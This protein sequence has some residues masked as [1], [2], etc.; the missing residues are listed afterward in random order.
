MAS[1]LNDYPRY[2]NQPAGKSVYNF[3]IGV[4]E[5]EKQRR[6]QQDM[7]FIEST[8]PDKGQ[9]RPNQAMVRQA[10][11][12]LPQVKPDS[13]TPISTG[14]PTADLSRNVSPDRYDPA[15]DRRGQRNAFEQPLMA[16]G[17]QPTNF[18]GVMY[19][20]QG[21]QTEYQQPKGSMTFQGGA[22]GVPGR[23][24]GGT[25]SVLG[26]RTPEEQ[27]AIDKRVKSI[28]SQTAAMRGLR[29][30]NRQEQ[31]M[32]TVEQEKQLSDMQ[33]MMR[34]LAPPPNTSRLD[35]QQA[36]LMQQLKDA[37]GIKGFGKRRQR[38]DAIRAAQLGLAQLAGLRGELNQQYGQ[39][40]GLAQSMM[41]NQAAQ[42]SAQAKALQDQQK[43]LANYGLTKEA[44]QIA[45]QKNELDAAQAGARQTLDQQRYSGDTALKMQEA[46]RRLYPS[47]AEQKLWYTEDI[48]NPGKPTLNIAA[49]GLSALPSD[50]AQVQPEGIYLQGETPVR[51]DENGN[52]VPIVGGLGMAVFLNRAMQMKKLGAI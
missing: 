7:A 8:L 40:A 1:P 41:Q 14:V 39:Q 45:Q 21:G 6:N 13:A 5:A 34:G 25:L 33:Q 29:N 43:W 38:E 30:A 12:V 36:A 15:V 50:K 3:L 11:P 26:G 4:P 16:E 23:Q 52:P 22:L 32:M 49:T 35:E 48:N 18:D 17:Y 19:R 27:A 37:Q 42:E 10:I 44:N 24:G 9:D 51:I 20:T 46:A 28:D 2:L 31:G 47:A